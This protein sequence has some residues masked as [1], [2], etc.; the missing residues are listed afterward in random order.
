MLM[1]NVNQG[2]LLSLM[3]RFLIALFAYVKSKSN[4][5]PMGTFVI[6]L[7]NSFCLFFQSWINWTSGWWK[8]CWMADFGQTGCSL[9]RSINNFAN[10]LMFSDAGLMMAVSSSPNLT[11]SWS[12]NKNNSLFSW[13]GIPISLRGGR[14]WSS[15]LGY[16]SLRSSSR[17]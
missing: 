2:H 3:P 13:T 4:W 15:W 8:M 17:K 10:W 11:Q 14:F 9:C 7:Q 12:T 1:F 5:I 6:C 16:L